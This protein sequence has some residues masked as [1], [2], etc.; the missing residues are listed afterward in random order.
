MSSFNPIERAI[1]RLLSKAPFLKKV[2]KTFY[3]RLVYIRHSKNYR[4][5]TA[6]ELKSFQFESESFFG[7]YDKSPNNND[8]LVLAHLSK[9]ATS[10]LP[11]VE[12]SVEVALFSPGLVEKI[13][14]A[15]TS[16]Y[17][18]Q[19]GARL[20][21][22][23]DEMFIYNDF[24]SVNQR[25]VSK[26]VSSKTSQ[27]VKSFA[28]PVQDSFG[29]DYFLSLNYRRL[30]SL[31]PDYGYRNLPLMI[32]AELR[33]LDKDGIWR[34]DYKTGESVLLI[35]LA[36]MCEVAPRPEFADALHKVNH[37]MIAPDGSHFIF[38]HRYLIGQRRF[39]RLMLADSNTGELRILSDYGM[40][41][42]C[43][44]A[45]NKTILGYMRG[46]DNKD[47]Y[48]LLDLD[49]ASFTHF[50]A[51]DGL[52]DGH[53][54]VHGDWFVADT[55]P[56][57]SRIQHLNLVNWKTGEVKKLGEFFQGFEYSGETRCDLHPRFS[58]C[59]KKVYFDSVFSGKRSLY[60]ME[61]EF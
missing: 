53:P 28:L 60:E 5:Q 13:W 54:H 6:F 11:S 9:S 39:D 47:A 43:F 61:I 33:S 3:S 1:A 44:W 17:N 48:W 55:Y 21:W 19:Q 15:D 49:S 29:T 45:D 51:L 4:Y 40:V 14:S 37:V 46:P 30:M 38:L 10:G 8:G 27:Q 36:Q 56:D 16:T 7:Y 35:S 52:G 58:S 23:D 22:L 26:V 2:A 25:Y 18:W 32:E 57:K 59:G 20:H 31:R 12:H 50:S 24:D 34:T 42:H 41:S